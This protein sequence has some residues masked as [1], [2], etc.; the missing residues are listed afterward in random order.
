MSHP[1][2][3][4]ASTDCWPTPAELRSALRQARCRLE[5]GLDAYRELL[6]YDAST[7]YDARHL[8]RFFKESHLDLSVAFWQAHDE[9]AREEAR[10]HRGM[11]AVLEGLFGDHVPG[12]EVTWRRALAERAADPGALA[13]E[14]R[15]EFEVLLA[16]SYDELVTV[17]A[18]RANLAAY[19]RLGPEMARFIR[20]VI[21]DE[22]AHYA[23]FL[24][25]LVN[26][27]KARLGEAPERLAGI[28]SRLDAAPYGNVFLFDHHGP[29]Y[30]PRLKQ[31]AAE[32]L[33]GQL[34]AC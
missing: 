20:L 33:L 1:S 13:A 2:T 12:S 34:A 29:E 26:E 18:Y 4:T 6:W 7:E 16:A 28:R 23:S 5:G 17:R 30:T 31:R 3:F 24:G 19:D 14:L 10:H 25:L 11:L 21:A 27:H 8:T 9:W 32:V 22:A 15:D